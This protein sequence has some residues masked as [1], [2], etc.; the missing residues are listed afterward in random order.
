MFIDFVEAMWKISIQFV[1]IL[2]LKLFY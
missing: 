2:L 1:A